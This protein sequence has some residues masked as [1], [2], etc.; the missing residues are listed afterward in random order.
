MTGARLDMHGDS[1]LQDQAQEMSTGKLFTAR[2]D[3]LNKID[4]KQG[5]SQ[6]LLVVEGNVSCGSG[7]SHVFLV[8]DRL[9][10]SS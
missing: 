9:L 1:L 7:E 10:M 5:C 8:S 4:K 2:K 6:Q 3:S